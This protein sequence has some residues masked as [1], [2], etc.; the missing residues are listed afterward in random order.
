MTAMCRTIV[1]RVSSGRFPV[2]FAEAFVMAMT[3][4]VSADVSSARSLG[5]KGEKLWL[6]VG[7][8]EA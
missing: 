7:I 4:S 2:S 1:M 5:M 8:V 6:V 3:L